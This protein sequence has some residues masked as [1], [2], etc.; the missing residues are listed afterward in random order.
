MQPRDGR[1]KAEPKPAAL[2]VPALL[3]TFPW[4]LPTRKNYPG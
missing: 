3:S 2:L 4:A 1:D